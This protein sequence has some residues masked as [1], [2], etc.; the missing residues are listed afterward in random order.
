MN[1]Q[2]FESKRYQQEA[3]K[4]LR[5]RRQKE[6]MGKAPSVNHKRAEQREKWESALRGKREKLVEEQVDLDQ[7]KDAREINPHLLTI[8]R[9]VLVDICSELLVGIRA[10]DI[11]SIEHDEQ[12]AVLSKAA[13]P[14]SD[15]TEVLAG[16]KTKDYLRVSLDATSGVLGGAFAA[17]G[18]DEDLQLIKSVSVS[19]ASAA[20]IESLLS[21]TS[22][23]Q[24]QT[25]SP[26][27]LFSTISWEEKLKN[28]H[29]Q[30]CF[31]T[32]VNII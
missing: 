18:K 1:A 13:E 29:A 9:D 5:E 20:D 25:L 30:L 31:P 17:L 12:L 15:K 7:L 23:D 19:G 2:A 14:I 27:I 10:K 11:Q 32:N 8:S 16:D 24:S 3:L 4:R 22:S 26:H 28:F 21:N 6:G